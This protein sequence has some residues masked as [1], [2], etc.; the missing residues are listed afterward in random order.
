MKRLPEYVIFLQAISLTD[1]TRPALFVKVWAQTQETL[2]K[3]AYEA[4]NEMS[5]GG[6]AVGEVLSLSILNCEAGMIAMGHVATTLPTWEEMVTK[7]L[8]TPSILYN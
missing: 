8:L 4:L 6:R 5:E 3:L 7:G 1:P 2:T